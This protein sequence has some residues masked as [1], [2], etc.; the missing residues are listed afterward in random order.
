MFQQILGPQA[1]N[2]FRDLRVVNYKLTVVLVLSLLS[3]GD[4]EVNPGPK[5]KLSKL[6][7]CHWNVNSIL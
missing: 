4:I 2:E 6:S 7:Y 1:A 5:R 3:H